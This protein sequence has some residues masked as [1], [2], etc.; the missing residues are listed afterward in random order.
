MKIRDR[1]SLQFTILSAVLLL[2]VLTGIYLLTAGNRKN[3]FYGHL[4]DRAIINA[5]LFLAQDNLSE[6]KFRDVQKKFPQSLPGE[7][8]RI[9]NDSDQPAFIKDSSFQWPK[10]VIDRVRRQKNITYSEGDRQTTGI[11]YIDN[12]GNFTVLASAIDTSGFEKMRQL[13]WVMLIAFFISV[14]ILF[15]AGRL[16][17]RAAL[18]PMIKV[19]NDVKFIRSSSLNKRLQ[20]K[21]GKDEINELAVTFNNLLEHLEQ[22][23]EAQG[24]FVTHASHELRTPVTALIGDVEVTLSQERDKEEYKKTLEGVLTESGKL[25]DLINNLVDL[26]QTNVDITEFQD[27]RLDELLW[28]VKDQWSDKAPENRIHLQYDLPEDARKYTIQGNHYLLFIALSN[29]LKNAIKFS[30]NRVVTCRLYLQNNAPVISIRDTGIG[31]GKEDIPNIFQPFYRGANA[32][33]YAGYGVGLSLADKIFRLHNVSVRIN[34]ELGKGTEFR[35]F[36]SI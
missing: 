23:F 17:A 20:T 9:Y 8:V 1:L 21:E 5:E 10:E 29:I 7:I 12:S 26:A 6:E 24:S 25:N 3:D 35:L 14:F 4:L 34:S 19:I 30:D 28:Q 15:F 13:F 18:A 2:L 27:L 22:S 16:F 32:I 33:G 36:F 31:I 11:Y